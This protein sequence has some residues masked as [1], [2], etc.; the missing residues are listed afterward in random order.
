L[1]PPTPWQYQQEEAD[2]GT[3]LSGYDPEPKSSHKAVI[4]DTTKVGKALRNQTQAKLEQEKKFDAKPKSL[5][6]FL[7]ELGEQEMDCYW[8][9]H[10]ILTYTVGT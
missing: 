3:G 4:H 5:K 1:I 2:A 7:R 8:G 9:Q 10:G 6:G